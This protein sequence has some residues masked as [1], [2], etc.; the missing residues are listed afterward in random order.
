M[1][2]LPQSPEGVGVVGTLRNDA[3][4]MEVH[5]AKE[6]TLVHVGCVNLLVL[7]TIIVYI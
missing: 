5:I 2:R 4:S 7:Q 3:D 1:A 6:T